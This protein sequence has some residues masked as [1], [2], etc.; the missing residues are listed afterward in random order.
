LNS[1]TAATDR[2]QGYQAGQN[3]PRTVTAGLSEAAKSAESLGRGHSDD[4]AV[5]NLV[6]GARTSRSLDPDLV[7]RILATEI[8][9]PTNTITSSAGITATVTPRHRRRR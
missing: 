7:A 6:G 2:L 5:I 4:A 1:V 8:G 9:V 3:N